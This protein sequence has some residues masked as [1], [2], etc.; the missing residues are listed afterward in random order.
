MRRARANRTRVAEEAKTQPSS[1]RE[2][3]SPLEPQPAQPQIDVLTHL[4]PILVAFQQT[5]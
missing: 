5:Q 3:T 1:H 4:L 2:A